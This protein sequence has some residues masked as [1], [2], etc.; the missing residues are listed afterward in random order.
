[1]A[2]SPALPRTSRRSVTPP[3][4]QPFPPN[5]SGSRPTVAAIAFTSRRKSDVFH[6]ET[7]SAPMKSGALL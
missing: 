2:A 6:A 1:M 5:S 4:R 7:P 3:M